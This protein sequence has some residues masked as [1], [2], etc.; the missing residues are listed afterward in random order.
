MLTTY[1][2]AFPAFE[3][4]ND[5]IDKLNSWNLR[6]LIHI[7]DDDEQR[8][9]IVILHKNIYNHYKVREFLESYNYSLKSFNRS[10]SSLFE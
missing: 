5:F 8:Y 1:A 3:D 7:E 4:F 10:L 6:H 2:I 9:F